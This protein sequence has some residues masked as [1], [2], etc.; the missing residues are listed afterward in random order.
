MEWGV[1]VVGRVFVHVDDVTSVFIIGD[2]L[3]HILR[4]LEVAHESH[5]PLSGYR[6]LRVLLSRRLHLNHARSETVIIDQLIS[7][8]E[9]L[10]TVTDISIQR[11]LLPRILSSLVQ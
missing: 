3:L 10:E 4:R 11:Y 6:P 9:S 8:L 2:E 1:W 5:L 7:S